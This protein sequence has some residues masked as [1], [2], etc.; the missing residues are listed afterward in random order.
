MARSSKGAASDRLRVVLE[1]L[2]DRSA[3][4]LITSEVRALLDTQ[5]AEVAA[6]MGNVEG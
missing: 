4:H 2:H 3:A 1:S 6:F 5:F